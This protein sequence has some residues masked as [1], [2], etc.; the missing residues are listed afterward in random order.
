MVSY[1]L[2]QFIASLNPWPFCRRCCAL[3]FIWHG[4]KW[5]R[6]VNN[7]WRTIVVSNCCVL[8]CQLE[9]GEATVRGM[10]SLTQSWPWWANK[11]WVFLSLVRFVCLSFPLW[12]TFRIDNSVCVCARAMETKICP[13]SER[14]LTPVA[15]VRSL[16]NQRA[17][18]PTADDLIRWASSSCLADTL[19]LFPLCPSVPCGTCHCHLLSCTSVCF[20]SL[21]EE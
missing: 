4:N 19:L 5:F 11:I 18:F 14:V 6:R 15:G 1:T 12:S 3:S 7:T 16:T 9:Q 2:C 17:T 8:S 13:E 21:F 20:I 10:Y